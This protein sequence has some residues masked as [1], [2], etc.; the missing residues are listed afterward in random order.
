MQ[1]LVTKYGDQILQSIQHLS[2]KLDLSL[3]GVGIVEATQPS[4]NSSKA[5]TTRKQPA[6]LPPAKY[7]AWKMWQEDGLS[8]EQIAVWFIYCFK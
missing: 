1:H 8:A 5:Y 3:D 6:D 7:A 4:N 2:K